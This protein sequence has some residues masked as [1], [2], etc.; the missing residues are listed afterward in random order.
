[1]MVKSFVQNAQQHVILASAQSSSNETI[2]ILAEVAGLNLPP[3]I[4]EELQESYPAFEAMVRRL[5]RNNSIFQ[6]SAHSF[7]ADRVAGYADPLQHWEG[8]PK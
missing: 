3:H 8:E 2:R 4:L 7:N 5:P 1:M 6:D